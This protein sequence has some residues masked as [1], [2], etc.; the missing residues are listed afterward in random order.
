VRKIM[1]STISILLIAFGLSAVLR[2]YRV[3]LNGDADLVWNA[4]QAYLFIGVT[5][6]GYRLNYLQYVGDLLKERLGGVTSA[7]DA[8]HAVI[9]FRLTP[10]AI[11]RHNAADIS[12]DFYTPFENNIYANRQGEMWTWAGDHFEKASPEKRAKFESSGRQLEPTFTN[13]DGWSKQNSIFGGKFGKTDFEVKLGSGPLKVIA[14][15]DQSKGQL[16]ID[17]LR[18]GQSPERVWELDGRTRKITEAEYNEIF[19]KM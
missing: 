1:L 7:D 5:S 18:P 13:I 3:R 9:V 12:L 16:S 8:R 14:N 2:T 11:Q 10:E 17:L 19:G 4:D 15:S 6:W